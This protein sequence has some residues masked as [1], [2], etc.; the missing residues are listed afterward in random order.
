VN[1]RD[2]AVLAAF[3]EV[4]GWSDALVLHYAQCESTCVPICGHEE[5]NCPEVPGWIND[6]SL[7]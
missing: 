6:E 1:D 5:M 7:R 2:A 4:T 3:R